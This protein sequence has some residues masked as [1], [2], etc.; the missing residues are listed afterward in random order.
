MIVWARDAVEASS[1]LSLSELTVKVL[2]NHCD[3]SKESIVTRGELND[4]VSI[5]VVGELSLGLFVVA[6]ITDALRMH[7]LETL[8]WATCFMV[9]VFGIEL[10]ASRDGAT[11]SFNESILAIE[12][13]NTLPHID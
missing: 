9:V 8:K 10:K 12:L 3:G 2:V 4:S 6:E 11:A 1:G 13:I 5:R 7:S